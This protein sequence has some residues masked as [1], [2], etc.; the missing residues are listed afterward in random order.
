MKRYAAFTCLLATLMVPSMA[1]ATPEDDSLKLQVRSG[2]PVVEGVYVNGHGPYRFL[3]D[4]GATLNVIDAKIAAS[5]DMPMTFSTQLTSS[6]GVTTAHGCE[7]ADIHVGSAT[8]TAQPF[9]FSGADALRE[10]S[11]GIQGVLGEAFLSGFDYLLDLRGG[12]LTFGSAAQ[13]SQGTRISFRLS[14]GRPVVSTSLGSLVLDTGAATMIRFRVSGSQNTS[15]MVT[16]TGRSLAGSV[17][18]TL[19][20]GGHQF[21]GG[22]AVALPTSPETDVDGLMAVSPFRSIYVSNSEGY[23]VLQ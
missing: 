21:W 8:A 10:I 11:P 15:V 7:S 17:D 9:L 2:R 20:I 5:I 4:T 23:V 13:V 14:N 18:S 1:S 6:S 22:D 16:A 19:R 3:I 12:R